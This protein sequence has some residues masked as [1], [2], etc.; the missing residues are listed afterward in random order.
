M[1]KKFLHCLALC[2]AMLVSFTGCGGFVDISEETPVST[3]NTSASTTNATTAAVSTT[4]SD[5]ATTSATTA[6]S[7]TGSSTASTSRTTIATTVASTTA[8]TAVTSALPT[9]D[10]LIQ[11]KITDMTIGEKV[12]QMLLISCHEANADTN[13]AQ[14]GAGGVCLYADAFKGKTS[15][16]VSSMTAN[17]QASS[18]IPMLI[19][20]DEEGGDVVRVS[21]N[22]QLRR[23]PFQSPRKLFEMGG[24]DLIQSDTKEKMHLLKSLGINVNLA[25]VCDVPLTNTDYIYD[26]CFSLD[27]K[28]TSKY[29]QTVVSIMETEKVGCSLKHFPGYGG[30]A[31]THKGMGYDSRDYNAFE[32]SDF[33]PFQSGIAAGADSVMVSHNIVTCMDDKNPASLSPEV[34]RILREKLGF[35]GVVITDDLYMDAIVQFCGTEN[36]AVVA[37]EAG[38]DLLCCPNFDEAYNAIMKAVESGRISEDR[39]NQSVVRIFTW[40][41]ELSLLS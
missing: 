39:I 6:T 22:N 41:E 1:R 31:D 26:R 15:A 32:T 13:A 25:P 9:S 8:T 7:T 27:A 16:Q 12:A 30:S 37:V 33:L 38:N 17:L 20:V 14:K 11:K 34:H 3:S 35:K 21:L 40:K 29:I 4:A 19:S 5:K 28:D 24:W 23:V 2:S 10:P 36:A 18:K